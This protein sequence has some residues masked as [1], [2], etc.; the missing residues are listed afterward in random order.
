MDLI[1]LC[2]VNEIVSRIDSQLEAETLLR[3]IDF[4]DRATIKYFKDARTDAECVVFDDV[5]VNV[6]HFIFKGTNS[7]KDW[8]S[9]MNF[10]PVTIEPDH[11]GLKIHQG[12]YEQYASLSSWLKKEVVEDSGLKRKKLVLSGHSLGGALAT[13]CAI[14]MQCISET[15]VKRV[16]TFGSPRCLCDDMAEWYNKRLKSRTIRVL[17]CMDTVPK[18]PPSGPIFRFTHVDS[19]KFEF[20]FGGC[21]ILADT[22]S[23]SNTVGSALYCYRRLTG[24]FKGL[25]LRS[26]PHMLTTYL[27]NME[28]FTFF[29]QFPVY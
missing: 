27:E 19:T 1:Q 14:Y 18:L 17:N 5:N 25:M 28:G 2:N 6:K 26:G 10:F 11:P 8:E 29:T 12:F 24:F 20:K 13:I 3:D 4:I 21:A 16:V 7:S 9:N 22:L 23:E 15:L